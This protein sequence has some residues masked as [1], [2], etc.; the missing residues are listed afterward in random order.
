MATVTH[1]GRNIISNSQGGWVWSGTVK[2]L[3][4]MQSVT[5]AKATRAKLKR[6]ANKTVRHPIAV[7]FVGTLAEVKSFKTAIGNLYDGTVGTLTV[8]LESGGND[9]VNRCA[10]TGEPSFGEMQRV[11]PTD[12]GAAQY[13]IDVNLE[14]EEL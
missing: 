2:P 7:T 10:F 9:T 5:L 3:Y 12:G 6:Y 13:L 11:E 1:A 8:P 14:V 4:N